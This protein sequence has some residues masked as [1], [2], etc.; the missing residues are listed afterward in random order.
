MDGA[1]GPLDPRARCPLMD[2]AQSPM[3]FR[4]LQR[5]AR[6]RNPHRR[7]IGRHRVAPSDLIGREATER[8]G[9]SIDGV[10]LD[11]FLQAPTALAD[12][13]STIARLVRCAN[14]ERLWH[15]S[16]RSQVP[17]TFVLAMPTRHAALVENEARLRRASRS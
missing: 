2:L 7:A 13:R 1:G 5:L 8:L 12:G 16:G 11:A 3:V 10:P 15:G 9:A 4:A 6:S 17:L 14:E